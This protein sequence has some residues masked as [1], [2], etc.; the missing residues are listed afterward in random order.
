MFYKYV[1]G[2]FGLYTRDENRRRIKFEA[3]DKTQ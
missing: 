1:Y 2:V 3:L